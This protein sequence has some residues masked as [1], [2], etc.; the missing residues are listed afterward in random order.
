MKKQFQCIFNSLIWL[1]LLTSSAC[2]P[3]ELEQDR[4][5]NFVIIFC[6]DLGYG[7]TGPYGN[8][9]HKTPHLNRMAEEGVLLADFYS[10]SGLCTPS[11]SSLMTGCYAQR[12]DMDVNARPFGSVG[13]QV[14]FPRA[15]KGLHPAEVTIAELL[16][17]QG[18]VTGCIG[19]WHLGDQPQFLPTR[20]GFDYYYGIPYSND[21]NR[22]FC[23]LPLMRGEEVIEAPVDQTTLTRRYTEAALD[24]L[25]R[26]KE[27]PFLLYFPHSMP[28]NPLFAGAEFRGK[29]DN[30]IYGDVIEEIDWSVGQILD[31]L[32]AN[33]LDRNTM[34]FFTSDNGA[35]PSF[36]G[37]NQPLAGWKGSTMEGGQRVPAIFWW[38]GK[39]V[40]NKVEGVMATMMDLFPTL[41]HL[42]NS[43]LPDDRIL[44]GHNIWPLLIG[45]Q[46]TSPYD[47]FY[48]FQLEQLMA[49]RQG[50]WKLHLPLDSMYG[51]WH[52]GDIVKGRPGALYN[53]REDVSESINRMDDHPDLVRALLD[54]AEKVRQEL[55]DI[56]I[57]G[58]AVRP[59]AIIENPTARLLPED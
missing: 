2:Q 11:R 46:T 17:D 47:Y 25:E 4:P 34:V 37:S 8:T 7:D 59:A 12:I 40:P 31:F 29:S 10:S 36:G 49:I 20:R 58:T 28:H 53:L 41:A 21:M 43:A 54:Q 18:Y 16:K 39:L 56:D 23:P 45:E 13:R 52:R 55:G 51:R 14:L 33:D 6:D 3:S 19:K 5:V 27:E 26:S 22:D 1:S 57:P 50:D 30:G 38:P 35:A 42:T 44:D 48:Y 15:K 9:V 24:F 32:R